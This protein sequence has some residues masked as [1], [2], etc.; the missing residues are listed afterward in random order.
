M[1]INEYVYNLYVY[2]FCIGNIFFLRQ[3][4]KSI[5]IFFFI[6]FMHLFFGNFIIYTF[7]I[8]VSIKSQQGPTTETSQF[9]NE[10]QLHNFLFF[11]CT[12]FSVLILALYKSRNQIRQ[13][14]LYKILVF[15]FKNF[16][17]RVFRFLHEEECQFVSLFFQFSRK[18]SF[19]QQYGQI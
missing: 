13:N 2:N 11:F 18:A 14:F 15:K 17:H 5:R 19:I 6:D 16:T 3:F 4:F 10:R 9:C 1:S 8:F 7:L 12:T